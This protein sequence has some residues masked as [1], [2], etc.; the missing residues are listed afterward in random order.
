MAKV[1]IQGHA[2]GTGIL[3]V[4]APNTSTDR[5]ITLPD[6]TGTLL[7]SDGDGSSLT[8]IDA[9]TVATTAPGSPS[10]GDL[11]FNSDTSEVSDI[12]AKSMAVYNGTDWDTMTN[13]IIAT[14]GTVTTD[15]AYKVHTFLSSGTFF[16]D[17]DVTCECLIVA[18]GGGGGGNHGGGGGA[19]GLVYHATKSISAGSYTITVGAGGTGRLNGDTGTNGSDTTFT[20]FTADGGG[21]SGSYINTLSP[22]TGGSG[23][24]GAS[25][26]GTTKVG[27][28]ATQGD[29]GGGTG[30]GNEGGDAF[31]GGTDW[32]GGGGGGAGAAGGDALTAGDGGDGGDGREYSISGSATYYA[33]GG[34]GCCRVDYPAL[35]GQGGNGGGGIGSSGSGYAPGNGTANTGGGG[36]GSREETP[37]GGSGGSGV[38]FIKYLF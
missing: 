23:G 13:A 9:A 18:G 11:W 2:S 22:S 7:N 10:T 37:R 8:G 31:V 36:G 4:T 32:P 3:T 35:R 14:G 16:I 28:A 27:A 29:S 33:G 15:G 24:G 17:T 25:R 26:D 12:A 6:A 20:D 21:V 19:G 30:Y 34:G 5:T 38:V 1:K